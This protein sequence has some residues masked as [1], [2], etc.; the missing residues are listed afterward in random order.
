MT[1][2]KGRGKGLPTSLLRGNLKLNFACFLGE[3]M[4]F[5]K[6]FGISLLSALLVLWGVPSILCGASATPSPSALYL[7]WEG[8]PTSS[9]V[10]HWLSKQRDRDSEVLFRRLGVSSWQ[11]VH[12][13]RL[14]LPGTPYGVHRVGLTGLQP[15]TDYEFQI[16]QKEGVYRFRTMPK[17][18]NREIRW[19]IG[20]DAYL[21]SGLFQRMNRWIRIADPDFVVVG[22]DLAYAYRRRWSVKEGGI[23]RWKDFF[24][25]WKQQIVGSDGRLIPIVPVLGNH[26]VKKKATPS[27]QLVCRLFAGLDWNAP[28]RVLD[29]G[30][31]LSL[32]LLD[33]GHISPIGGSQTTW[34]AQTLAEREETPH[35]IAAY[36]IG[37]Y[38]SVYSYLGAVPQQIRKAWSPLFEQHGVKLAFEHHNHA[39]KRTFP[40]REGEKVKD[41]VIYLGDGSWGAPARNLKNNGAW[42]LEK[43][44]SAN[45]VCLV[46]LNRSGL[47]VQAVN[48]D[49]T[50][51]D[52]FTIWQKGQ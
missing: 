38:P 10:I 14:S 18:L 13:E 15:G 41:G 6:I 39:Y 49:G 17:Q 3:T 1:D 50:P 16:G 48:I 26:D 25:L 40:I 20:G 36:H 43:A 45:A 37:A 23:T 42:Y 4:F 52:T 24:C 32:W 12:G 51:I 27:Q 2:K 33:S 21:S 44:E 35:K 47:R 22:G 46:Q 30:N 19:V 31:Y 5:C 8:D 9:M 11:A 34:L 28:Y 7:S 29:F